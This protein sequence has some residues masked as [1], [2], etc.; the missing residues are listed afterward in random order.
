MLWKKIIILSATGAALGAAAPVFAEH[1]RWA[2]DQSYRSQYYAPRPIAVHP[3]RYESRP[4]VAY[5][6]PDYYGAPPMST[7]RGYRN[8]G[9]PPMPAYRGY[10]NY[11]R[12]AGG[13]LA[14]A[15][16]G[17]LIGGSVTYGDQQFA[18]VAIGSMLG[19]VI[20]HEL[21]D[22][23]SSRRSRNW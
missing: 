2:P 10:Y 9:P 13:A 1:P 21:A 4:F 7:Y 23:H 16:A 20:G 17:A 19:A 14:G 18:G 6:A 3:H 12:A 5:R 22:G 8:Y 15:L 11:D